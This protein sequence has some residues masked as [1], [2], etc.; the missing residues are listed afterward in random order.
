MHLRR[1]KKIT[2][3]FIHEISLISVNFIVNSVVSS[4]IS[5]NQSSLIMIYMYSISLNKCPLKQLY[6]FVNISIFTIRFLF[7]SDIGINL[8]LQ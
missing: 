3:Q 2:A 8:R 7:K 6:G 5:D 4:I 1:M